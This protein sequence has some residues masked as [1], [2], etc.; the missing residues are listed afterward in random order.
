VLEPT[1]LVHQTVTGSVGK[2]PPD[3]V[4][5]RDP[6]RAEGMA[7]TE[8][9]TARVH[10]RVVAVLSDCPSPA[11]RADLQVLQVNGL[12]DGEGIVNLDD[13]QLPRVDA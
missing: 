2:R 9:T 4:Q 1:R 7:A 11:A 5:L 13:I 6:G 8:Q 12:R 10:D 3:R